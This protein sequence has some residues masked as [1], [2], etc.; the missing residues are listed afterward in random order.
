MVFGEEKPFNVINI[1]DRL[2][3]D[4]ITGNVPH[5]T[6]Q[7][8]SKNWYNIFSFVSLKRHKPICSR[9]V[10]LVDNSMAFSEFVG[11]AKEESILVAGDILIIDNRS[12]HFS[13]D[14]ESIQE[15]LW[16]QYN[17]LLTPLPP[18]HP[19]FNPTELVFQ[20]VVTKL[21]LLHINSSQEIDILPE[22][23]RT[24]QSISCSEV[25]KF[26]YNCGYLK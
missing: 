11:V 14:N 2:R 15:V 1:Y 24:V 16:Q 26:Y 12:I 19:E 18:Y 20:A 4:P 23:R 22:V 21:H 6:C 25:R 3:R 10:D 13:G 9:V 7:A 5:L 8:N 17:I